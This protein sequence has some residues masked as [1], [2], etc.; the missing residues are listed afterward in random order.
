MTSCAAP[1]NGPSY[2]PEDICAASALLNKGLP[3]LLDA[4]GI[5]PLEGRLAKA[6][7]F[8]AALFSAGLAT[9]GESTPTD[10]AFSGTSPGLSGIDNAPFLDGRYLM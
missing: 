9:F 10:A 1:D 5:I 2:T 8:V 3:T 4:V 6:T 7:Q